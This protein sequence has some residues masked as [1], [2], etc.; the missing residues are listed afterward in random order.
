MSLPLD[1][2]S[3]VLALPESDRL[4]LATEL[5]ATVSPDVSGVSGE[6]WLSELKRRRDVFERDRSTGVPWPELKQD[7]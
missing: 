5:L 7:G 2:R 6:E 3:A 1:L 4:E